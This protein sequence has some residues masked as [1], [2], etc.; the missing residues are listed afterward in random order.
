MENVAHSK[1]QTILYTMD[2]DL[3][4]LTAFG[5]DFDQIMDGEASIPPEGA[6]FDIEFGGTIAGPKVNGKVVG[7]DYLNM[8]ADGRTNLNIYLK[9]ETEDGHNISAQVTGNASPRPDSKV[10]DIRENG[11]MFTSSEKYKWVNGLQV[12]ATGTVDRNT[13]KIELTGYAD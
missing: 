11:T 7:I 10:I 9:I 3:T 12:W 1:T 6:R 8:R 5:S 4:G 13:G 2:L